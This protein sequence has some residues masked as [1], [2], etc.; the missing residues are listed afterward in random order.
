MHRE[1]SERRCSAQR[2]FERLAPMPDFSLDGKVALVT[3]GNS[4][5]GR[6]IAFA[7]AEHGARV[8]I[9]A[10]NEE[11]NQ[12][13]TKELGEEA[14]A[15]AVDVGDADAVAKAVDDVFEDFG[16]LDI[17]VNN[18]GIAR[19]TPAPGHPPDRAAGVRRADPA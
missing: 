19:G 18:A 14:K 8:A 4:G 16:S 7:L 13:T 6:G 9:A 5:I 12:Q 11:R 17:L 1:R 10:R 2:G 3:G 15:Y